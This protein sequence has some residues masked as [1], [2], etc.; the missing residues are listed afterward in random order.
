[1]NLFRDYQGISLPDA[2]TER[3]F[4]G[5]SRDVPPVTWKRPVTDR[6]SS[7]KLWHPG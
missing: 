4:V 7:T 2:E 3:A 5:G 1:M 6:A